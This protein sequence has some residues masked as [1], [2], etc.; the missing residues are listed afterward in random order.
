[1][2]FINPLK[3]SISYLEPALLGQGVRFYVLANVVVAAQDD[4]A[5]VHYTTLITGFDYVC[6]VIYSNSIKHSPI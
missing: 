4:I 6:E 5:A 1:M 3:E 2:N